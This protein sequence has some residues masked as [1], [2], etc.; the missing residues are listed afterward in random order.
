[1]HLF[2]F[3]EFNVYSSLLL[4]LV[5][6]G[7]IFFIVLWWRGWRENRLADK[8][9]AI[10]LLLLSVRVANWMLGFAGWY[11]SHDG[12]TTFMFY[13]SWSNNLAYGPLIW[14]YFRSLTNHK[15]RLIGNQ[16]LHF[17]PFVLSLII[18]M[19]LFVDDIVINHWVSGKPLPYFHGTRGHFAE[20]GLGIFDDILFIIS[21]LSIIIYFLYTTMQFRKYYIYIN[22]HFS[23]TETISFKWLRNFL[24]AFLCGLMIWIGFYLFEAI[25][26]NPAS[27]IQSWYGHFTWGVIIYYLSI[28]GFGTHPNFQLPLNFNPRQD[29]NNQ[30]IK[31]IE[32]SPWEEKLKT[33]INQQ[34][35]YLN[36][37]LTLTEL[38]QQLNT[39]PAVISKTIN[40]CFKQNF[41]DYINAHRVEDVKKRMIESEYQH[42]TLLGL[43]ME[44]GFNSK[45][46]FNRA[47]KKHTQLSP[48]EYI[49]SQI[50]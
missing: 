39:S 43:A 1:M 27:Y 32:E 21:Y 20:F 36:P 29:K 25:T 44:S 24:I 46:T 19:V 7:L 35:P 6:Q 9:L 5:L 8:L 11:D 26:Q 22:H 13:F 17:L 23:E 50:K 42:L 37:Q 41:N 14:L 47:F 30:K 48:T 34:K 12:H 18:Q 40:S 38:A 33:H 49:K 4:P 45:A 16:W 2:I 28:G 15:F 10:L 3:F 31:A